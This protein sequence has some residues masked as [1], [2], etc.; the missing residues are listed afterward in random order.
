MPVRTYGTNEVMRRK[1]TILS[2]QKVKELDRKAT[3]CSRRMT[4]IDLSVWK[5]ILGGEDV[6]RAID[7]TNE[8]TKITQS[9]AATPGVK[10]PR[11][12]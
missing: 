4:G 7:D 3:E 11:V 1:Q 12:K 8:P 6:I 9:A 10:G 2:S 5:S